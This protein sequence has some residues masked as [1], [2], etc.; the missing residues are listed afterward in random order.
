MDFIDYKIKLVTLF[1]NF[2]DYVPLIVIAPKTP[3]ISTE[4]KS[5]EL[6]KISKT[7]LSIYLIENCLAYA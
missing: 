4:S 3:A 7:I 6:G 2:S 1:T 5:N